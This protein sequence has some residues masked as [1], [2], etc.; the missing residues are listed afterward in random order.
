MVL[1]LLGPFATIS[2]YPSV[3]AATGRQAHQKAAPHKPPAI[4][5]KKPVMPFRTGEVLNYRVSWAAFSN[6]ASVQL[7]VLEQRNLYGWQTWHL[8]AAIHTVNSV[9]SLFTIDDEF[10]S[11]TDTTTLASHQYETYLDELGRKHDQ[12]LHLVSLG[13]APRAPGPGVAVLP[14]TRDPV[15][16][17][18][19][20]RGADW[21]RT[22]E[23]RLPVY[24]GR[25]VYE[26]VAK[27]EAVAE[28]VVAAG[29]NLPA[30]RISIRLFQNGQE[31]LALRFVI[32][33]ENNPA[34]TPV[35]IEAQL[36]FGSVR[37][38][39]TSAPQ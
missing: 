23:I 32:W 24:D 33:L 15:G 20:L 12:V 10:D 4:P 2:S 16:A 39:L 7:S 11:Y 14:G 3:R 21:D 26:M 8:R 9:R 28:N 31:N 13:E 29:K 19:A 22:P 37:A 17:F 36:P 34:R 35:V 18:Y 1:A 30:S 27:R 25:D 38:E 6:A 5:V